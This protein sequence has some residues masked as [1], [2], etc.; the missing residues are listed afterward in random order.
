MWFGWFDAPGLDGLLRARFTSVTR[1]L[2][3]S[4]SLEGHAA[5]SPNDPAPFALRVWRDDEQS[6]FAAVLAAAYAGS[7]AGRPFAPAGTPDEWRHY[8]RSLVDGNGCGTFGAGLSVVMDADDDALAAGALVSRLSPTTAH[9]VQI[10]VRTALQSAGIG[11]VV[12]EHLLARAA[13]AGCRHL[14]LMVSEANGA[15]RRLYERIGFTERA[16]FRYATPAPYQ[17]RTS[18]SDALPA[19]GTR[20]RR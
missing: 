10:A 13:A 8:V 14:T 2:Y 16:A 4:R 12:L 6:R 15:A 1:Y 5:A 11:R 20:T 17:P 18:T 3:L 7:D 19:G 9:L